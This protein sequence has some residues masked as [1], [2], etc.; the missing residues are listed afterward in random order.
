LF[1]LVNVVVSMDDGFYATPV[2]VSGLVYLPPMIEDNYPD[3]SESSTITRH[4]G[5]RDPDAGAPTHP[6]TPFEITFGYDF[7]DSSKIYAPGT[8]YFTLEYEYHG[9]ANSLGEHTKYYEFKNMG[10]ADRKELVWDYSSR[11]VT[12][13][14]EATAASDWGVVFINPRSFNPQS[15]SVV[16]ILM[17]VDKRY[18]YVVKSDWD[19]SE[20]VVLDPCMQSS[21]TTKILD[22]YTGNW[23]NRGG[24]GAPA[25]LRRTGDT[26]G[27]NGTI[28][29]LTC[30]TPILSGGVIPMTAYVE[31]LDVAP[32]RPKAVFPPGDYQVAYTYLIKTA[33]NKVLESKLSVWGEAHGASV[34]WKM[35]KVVNWGDLLSQPD[36]PRSNDYRKVSLNLYVKRSDPYFMDA[37]PTVY[38]AVEDVDIPSEHDRHEIRD[39][40]VCNADSCKVLKCFVNE[41]CPDGCECIDGK[42]G[43]KVVVEPPVD[44]VVPQPPPVVETPVVVSPPVVVSSPPPPVVTTVSSSPPPM[45]I[46]HYLLIALLCFCLLIT[47]SML[48][49][50]AYISTRSYGAFNPPN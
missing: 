29:K 36:W 2:D 21:I 15:G 34:P 32:M 48:V 45:S 49:Y 35:I 16:N 43:S 13:M 22:Y 42:C 12:S 27:D 3:D 40:K 11:Y 4:G 23:S 25:P 37:K 1:I 44:I 47:V 9:L 6:E 39:C 17:S 14:V 30:V 5:A 38:L 24:A 31:P 28:G 20:E 41:E 7:V 19:G 46:K 50:V 26:N 10:T 33:N 8:Y 18:F